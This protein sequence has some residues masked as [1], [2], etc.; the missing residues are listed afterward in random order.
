[1]FFLLFVKQKRVVQLQE[2]REIHKSKSIQQKQKELDDEK[3]LYPVFN[4]QNLT[5]PKPKEE[6]Q[7]AIVNIPNAPISTTKVVKKP[8]HRAKT[9]QP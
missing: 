5:P 1:M 8:R 4:P 2:N 6:I 3:K 9:I 7:E